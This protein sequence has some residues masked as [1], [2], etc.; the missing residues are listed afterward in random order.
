MLSVRT[1]PLHHFSRVSSVRPNTVNPV[2]SLRP[3]FHV[4]HFR[5]LSK[6]FVSG[7][8]ALVRYR[9]LCVCSYPVIHYRVHDRIIFLFFSLRPKLFRFLQLEPVAINPTVSGD[10]VRTVFL[11]YFVWTAKNTSNRKCWNR[12]GRQDGETNFGEER[13]SLSYLYGVAMGRGRTKRGTAPILSAT[14][15]LLLKFRL[16]HCSSCKRNDCGNIIEWL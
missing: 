6:L 16:V 14:L 5:F 1:R 11:E 12:A 7:V 4:R 3:T 13:E 9:V 2:S 8:C 15:T 10:T